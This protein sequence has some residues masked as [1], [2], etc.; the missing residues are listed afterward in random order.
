M[1]KL[2]ELQRNGELRQNAC[3]SFPT[4][5]PNLPELNCLDALH[6]ACAFLDCTRPTGG[7]L[8]GGT[9]PSCSISLS[10]WWTRARQQV[11][12]LLDVAQLSPLVMAK[13]APP[14]Q[15]QARTREIVSI[16]PMMEYTDRSFRQ[17]SHRLGQQP[18]FRSCHRCAACTTRA[19]PRS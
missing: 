2:M 18:L 19:C 4:Q 11:L 15:W 17:V 8:R 7:V 12:S 10:S 13:A 16:A 5:L 6:S 1:L 14:A 9:S 3:N